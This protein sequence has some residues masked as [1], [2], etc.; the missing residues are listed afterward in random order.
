VP[1]PQLFDN[2]S[3]LRHRIM[4]ARAEGKRVGLVP[5]M[6]ALHEG[7]ISLVEASQQVCDWTIVT[8]FVNP[9]QFAPDEDFEKYPRALDTDLELLSRFDSVAVFAPTVD[10]M[11]PPGESTIVK[12]PAICQP[13]EGAFRSTHFDGVA[14][15]VLKLFMAAPATMAFFGQKDYQQVRVIEDMVRDLLLPIEIVRCPTVRELDGLAM[16]SRNRYLSPA[17]REIALSISRSLNAAAD[18]IGNGCQDALAIKN[19]IEHSLQTAGIT[20]IDY[21]AIADPTSLKSIQTI[22]GRTVILIAAK[23][24]ETRLIDNRLIESPHPIP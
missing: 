4:A 17:E 12:A 9:T 19:E 20:S 2:L 6:G 13:W 7:H 8:I 18:K 23:V 14:T 10:T 16:S 15:I 21:V 5:T 1:L 24:G 11:Y 3:V 22:T